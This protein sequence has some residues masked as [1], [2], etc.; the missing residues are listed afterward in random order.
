MN[1]IRREERNEARDATIL[2]LAKLAEH[3][4]P[5]TGAHLERVQHY[6]RLLSRSLAETSRYAALIDNEFV[7]H[8]V[9]SSPLHDIGKVGIPDSVLLKAGRLTVDEFE[10][11][12]R[13]AAIGGDTLRPLVVKGR[14]QTFLQ[15]GMDIAYCHHEKFDGTGYPRGLAGEAIPLAARIL[16]LADVYDALTSKRVYKEAMSHDEAAF[17]IRRESAAHFDP[18]VVNAFNRCESEFRRL[19]EEMR[20]QAPAPAPQASAPAIEPMSCV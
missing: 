16:S 1:Q 4:D 3:R 13:H 7:D 6:C 19:A 18:D 8:I 17:I 2:A 15:M 20:D 14:G 12:K 9:R 5:E 11:M 10:V